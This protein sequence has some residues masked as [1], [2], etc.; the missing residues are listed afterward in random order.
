MSLKSLF[1]QPSK[2]PV[3]PKVVQELMQSLGRADVASFEIA[4]QL[5]SDPVLC[6]KLLRLANSAYFGASRNVANTR[7]AVQMLG[8]VMVRNLVMGLGLTVTFP[9]VAGMDMPAFWRYSLQSA[10][11]SRWLAREHALDEDLAFTIGLLH[12]LGHLVMHACPDAQIRE[13][14]ARVAPLSLARAQ[15]ERAAL[16]YQHGEVS[17]ELASHW[18]F[19]LAIVDPLRDVP[20]PLR[21]QPLRPLAAWVNVAAWR[22]RVDSLGWPAEQILATCPTDIGQ[23]LQRPFAW[24]AQESTLVGVGPGAMPAMPP[25]AKL[26]GGMQSLL[27]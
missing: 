22:A 10:C 7:D 17:A 5:D 26:V 25:M 21:K 20:D 4:A 1:D 9:S 13:L 12:G 16:G 2:L 8:F 11:V 19:P 18:R 3:L 6:A 14:D 23:A 27:G 24:S 15:A